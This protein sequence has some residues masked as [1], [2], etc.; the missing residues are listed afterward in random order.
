MPFAPGNVR[1]TGTSSASSTGL[2]SLLLLT[3]GLG[4]TALTFV[5]SDNDAAGQEAS[6]GVGALDGWLVWIKDQQKSMESMNQV[7]FFSKSFFV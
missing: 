4:A 5:Y 1:R 7:I 2:M 6:Y 3:K